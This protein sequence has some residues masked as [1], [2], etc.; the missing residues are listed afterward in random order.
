MTKNSQE[1][2]IFVFG[3]SCTQGFWDSQGGWAT[4]L[5]QYFDNFMVSAPNFPKHGFYYMVYPLGI[6]DDTTKSILERFEFETEKRMVWDKTEEI[7]VFAI[8]KNDTVLLD[9]HEYE[10]NIQDIIKRAK[11]F[12]NNI[13]FLEIAAVD[14]KLSQPVAWDNRFFYTNEKN[15]VYNEILNKVV[16]KE[17]VDVIPLF[18]EWQ[19]EDYTKLLADG[20][21]PN[22]DGHKYIFE[23]V[24]DFLLK[25]Y[26]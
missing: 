7:F 26:F 21:H 18:E 5:K 9:I 3:D 10:R 25:N 6:T 2:N 24:R 13:A 15:K 19:K 23:K 12:S 22:N 1:K 17:G 11:R 14:E 16:K 20:V 8:G 4:R